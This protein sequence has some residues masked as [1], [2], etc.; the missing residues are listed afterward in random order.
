MPRR[1]WRPDGKTRR[2][3]LCIRKHR[4]Y[5]QKRKCTQP[6]RHPCLFN[7]YH[8]GQG[9]ALIIRQSNELEQSLNNAVPHE[10]R[11]RVRYAETDQMGVVYYANYLVWMEIGRVE[12][13]R[14]LGLNYK[15]LE[16]SEGLFLSVV[17]SEC[18]YVFPARYDQEIA[19][20]T[21]VASA[22]SRMLE[23]AYKICDADSGQLLARGATKHIWLNRAMRPSRLPAQYQEVLHAISS[24][25]SSDR[26]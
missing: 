12:L 8:S 25:P 22:N 6:A 17:N 21:Q 1:S 13:V 19:I 11:I 2:R 18:R 5:Y 10:T 3:T 9:T 7:L 24:A 15:E 26:E 4:C 20:Q 14:S 16:Q 23:F